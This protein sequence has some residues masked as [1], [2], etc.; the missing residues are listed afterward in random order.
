M[1]SSRS[2][3]MGWELYIRIYT[4]THLRMYSYASPLPYK[5]RVSSIRDNRVSPLTCQPRPHL[6]SGF[7][8]GQLSSIEYNAS[9]LPLFLW[10]SL[11]LRRTC[12][13][14]ISNE[15][16]IGGGRGCGK[17]AHRWDGNLANSSITQTHR[18]GR[19]L[20]SKRIPPRLPPTP[21][22]MLFDLLHVVPV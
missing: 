20:L 8:R 21:K 16:F 22:K 2:V 11:F 1:I 15:P 6:D 12:R 14:E 4:H 3:L 7:V 13:T 18:F 19:Q 5:H 17:G 9:G 10:P